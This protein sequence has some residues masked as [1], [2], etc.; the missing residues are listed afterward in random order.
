[1]SALLGG[2][3]Q[4]LLVFIAVFALLALAY[5]L[6]RQFRRGQRESAAPARRR[7]SRI[8]VVD[9]ATIDWR[10]RLVLIRRDNVEHLLLVGGA[11]DVVVEP[12]VVRAAD[13]AHELVRPSTR[14][15]TG[16]TVLEPVPIPHSTMRPAKPGRAVRTEPN[17]PPEPAARRPHPAAP[18]FEGRPDWAESR[19]APPRPSAWRER[20]LGPEVLAGLAEGLTGAPITG[21][22]EKTAAPPR[23]APPR[24]SRA[25]PQPMPPGAPLGEA[26]ASSP[27][28]ADLG[29]LARRL[30]AALSRPRRG[31][32][33]RAHT[34]RSETAE[35]ET[36]THAPT[37]Q[38]GQPAATEPT[39]PARTEASAAPRERRPV[40]SI[41]DGLEQGMSG[42]LEPGTAAGSTRPQLDN[43]DEDRTDKGDTR[44]D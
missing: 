6:V 18:P 15:D 31:D 42:L 16:D 22:T 5:W 14:G 11:A 19:A 34:E 29:E 23:P 25:R 12:N 21:E 20:R 35:N 44:S 4:L 10:R 9:A 2:G 33:S 28:D 43:A 36:K 32:E 3:E 17:Q 13:A 37:P 1:M 8:A 26:K 24:V 40:R 7:H 41:Y 38:T 30:E 27:S 39:K